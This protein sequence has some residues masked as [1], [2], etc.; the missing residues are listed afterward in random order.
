MVSDSMKAFKDQLRVIGATLHEGGKDV[1][2]NPSL[3]SYQKQL[4]VKMNAHLEASMQRVVDAVDEAREAAPDIGDEEMVAVAKAAFD[5]VRRAFCDLIM[6]AGKTLTVHILVACYRHKLA[7]LA[8]RVPDCVAAA[9]RTHPRFLFLVPN[10]DN[11][12]EMLKEGLNP[13]FALSREEAKREGLPA[14]KHSGLCSK[15]GITPAQL[16]ELAEHTYVLSGGDGF[17]HVKF[18]NAWVVVGCLPKILNEIDNGHLRQCDF[19]HVFSDEGDVGNAPPPAGQTPEPKTWAYVQHF[20]D[21]SFFTFFTGTPSVWS[22]QPRP[23]ALDRRWAINP[24]A[25]CRVFPLLA[26]LACLA[27]SPEVGRL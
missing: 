11:I 14:R 8:N 20:F 12:L 7:S 24:L 25:C 10:I 27:Y 13:G 26:T 9:L 6:G 17:D 5:G 19:C 3:R 15:L 4:R 18:A 1:E 2:R 23:R 21:R 22:A 16:K